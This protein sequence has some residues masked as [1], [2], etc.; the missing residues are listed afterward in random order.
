MRPT[1]HHPWEQS[2]ITTI[3]EQTEI[4]SVKGV[5]GEDHHTAGSVARG[6]P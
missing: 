5:Q 1:A 4:Y 6:L 2:R 3:T